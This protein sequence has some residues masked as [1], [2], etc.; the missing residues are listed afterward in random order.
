M[1][2]CSVK[3][4]SELTDKFPHQNTGLIKIIKKKENIYITV[5]CCFS[6]TYFF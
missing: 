2:E 3:K 5:C 1:T 6:V 4:E